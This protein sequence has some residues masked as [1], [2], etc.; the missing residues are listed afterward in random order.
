MPGISIADA[1]KKEQLKAYGLKNHAQL[2]LVEEAIANGVD[3]NKEMFTP[4]EYAWSMTLYPAKR[5]MFLNRFAR[6]GTV[7]EVKEFIPTL[8]DIRAY[9]VRRKKDVPKK[10]SVFVG[11]THT[12]KRQ[13]ESREIIL[14]QYLEKFEPQTPNDLANLQLL[15]NSQQQRAGLSALIGEYI[16]NPNTA[17]S[18]DD[19]TKLMMMLDKLNAQC[20]NMEKILGIDR[21]SRDKRS[22]QEED[23]ERWKH[24]IQGAK[25]FLDTKITRLKHC[26]LDLGWTSPIFPEMGWTV[27]T[28]CPRCGKDI[29]EQI[30]QA[31]KKG[32]KQDVLRLAAQ[33][34]GDS[35]PP[36]GGAGDDDGGDP[37]PKPTFGKR[38]ARHRLYHPRV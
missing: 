15:V 17:P 22:D 5:G 25:E 37:G 34:D 27:V 38:H 35:V 18:A 26:G 14:E 12:T 23:P 16:S 30:S 1:A 28:K 19:Q 3:F 32:T 10:A 29:V 20:M 31:E 33:V 2:R 21:V 13:A 8:D 11:P 9:H 24:I 4:F 6:R 7:E 36:D